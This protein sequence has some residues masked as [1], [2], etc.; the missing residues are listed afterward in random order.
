MPL[1]ERL[2]AAEPQ[3]KNIAL[4]YQVCVSCVYYLL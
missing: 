3:L 1:A 2:G 4:Q